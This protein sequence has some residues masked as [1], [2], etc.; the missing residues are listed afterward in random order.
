MKLSIRVSRPAVPLCA[1][2]VSESMGLP[3]MQRA[4]ASL[5]MESGPQGNALIKT[6]PSMSSCRQSKR[7]DQLSVHDPGKSCGEFEALFEGFLSIE[8]LG[9]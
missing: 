9:E 5:V 4:T 3:L 6:T 7:P 1:S 8:I 2:T